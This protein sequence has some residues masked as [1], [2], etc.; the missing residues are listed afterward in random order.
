MFLKFI[1]VYVSTILFHIEPAI[2]W[3]VDD[4]IRDYQQ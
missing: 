3:P 4:Y 1:S 2:V